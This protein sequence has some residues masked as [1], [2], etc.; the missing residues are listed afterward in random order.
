MKKLLIALAILLIIVMALFIGGGIYVYMSIKPFMSSDNTESSQDQ[1]SDSVNEDKH[2][3]L[4]EDQEQSLEK[5]GIDPAKLPQELTPELEACL[6]E[7]L[8]QERAD[9][10]IGGED[11]GVLDFFKVKSCL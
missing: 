10:I 1:T 3:L 2:P 7:K 9:A 8:G 11:P 6:V 4:T 5:I